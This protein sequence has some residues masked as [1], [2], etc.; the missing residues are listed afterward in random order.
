[1]KIVVE[2]YEGFVH[3]WGMITVCLFANMFTLS[4]T[5][6]AK[7]FSVG[8]EIQDWSVNPSDLTERLIQTDIWTTKGQNLWVENN[9]TA[10]SMWNRKQLH[11]AVAFPRTTKI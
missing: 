10:N 2:V 8:S 1:M 11:L 6:F 3:F 5:R 4:K 9:V 7:D